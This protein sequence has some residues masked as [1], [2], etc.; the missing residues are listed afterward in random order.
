[1][2]LS[3]LQSTDEQLRILIAEVRRYQESSPERRK[4]LTRL[5]MVAQRLP[6]IY[7]SSHQDYS[8]ALS[9]T[10]EYVCKNINSFQA[11]TASLEEDVV[12]WINGYLYWRIRD[13][14]SKSQDIS[15]DE[16]FGTDDSNPGTR[17]DFVADPDV[18]LGLDLLDRAIQKNQDLHRQRLGLQLMRYIQQDPDE[19][20]QRCHLRQ[21]PD[22]NCQFLALRLLLKDPPDRIADISRQL[23]ISNQTLYASWKKKCLPLLREIALSFEA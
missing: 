19:E 9:L 23:G 3:N 11:K 5:L 18:P 16:P 20:L 14:H 2:S 12:K 10:W 4:A 22:C 21:Y 1:M 6:G 8:A 17:R 13:M 15:L 7:K